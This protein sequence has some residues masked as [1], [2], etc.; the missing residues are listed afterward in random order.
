MKTIYLII[1]LVLT[2]RLCNSQIYLILE[3][4]FIRPGILYNYNFNDIG[5]WSKVWYGNIKGEHSDGS[6]F[7]ADNIKV[8]TG[9]SKFYDGANWYA[10]INYNH[11]FN[12]NED[13]RIIQLDRI[14]RISFDIGVSLTRGRF[15]AIM[16]TDILNWES[17]IGISY[18]FKD[19]RC[20]AFKKPLKLKKL[21]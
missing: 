19:Y 20:A 6:A 8:S 14:H 11:F 1:L 15:S 7:Y 16:M 21:K 18:R 2:S 9:I 4:S 13:S 10:G 12:V 17:C 5:I 3:P